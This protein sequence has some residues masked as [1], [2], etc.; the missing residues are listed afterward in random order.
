MKFWRFLNHRTRNIRG[1]CCSC[2][3]SVSLSKRSRASCSASNC[4]P[5]R[6]RVNSMSSITSFGLQAHCGNG[7]SQGQQCCQCFQKIS[8]ETLLHMCT[9]GSRI[10]ITFGMRIKTGRLIRH[11][12]ST[13]RPAYATQR[14]ALK[15][16]ASSMSP[17]EACP[18]LR[19]ACFRSW[20]VR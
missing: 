4:G 18:P 2:C 11:C 17:V 1:R 13:G 7:S 8:E 12:R 6:S 16:T 3:R 20:K 10:G 9:I 19:M 5:P 15:A 14:A